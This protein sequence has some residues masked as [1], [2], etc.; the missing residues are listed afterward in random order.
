M[1]SNGDLSMFDEMH[2]GVY[3]ERGR[4]RNVESVSTDQILELA[5]FQ[6][7]KSIYMSDMVG[8]I[9]PGKA[10]DLIAVSLDKL[11]AVHKSN[12]IDY[13]VL[14]CKSSDVFMTMIDG[15]IF[16]ENGKFS[17]F[18]ESEIIEKGKEIM[19]KLVDRKL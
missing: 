15:K 9:E 16:F 17:Y 6:G 10:A 2:Y 14:S 11:S 19:T 12:L 18:D 5:T 13:I 7:A 3:S 1:A 8:S 4:S